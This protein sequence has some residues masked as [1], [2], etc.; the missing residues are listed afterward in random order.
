MD[1]FEDA[2]RLEREQEEEYVTLTLVPLPASRRKG[3]GIRIEALSREAPVFLP[4][5]DM[6]G[7]DPV[8]LLQ[9]LARRPAQEDLYLPGVRLASPPGGQSD[10][11]M[12]YNNGQL[13]WIH[14]SHVPGVIR[15]LRNL[16]RKMGL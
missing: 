6:Y 8:R 15:T 3:P 14:H 13:V 4:A 2:N 11:R 10:V 12:G 9:W 16:V 5:I 1:I 7:Q